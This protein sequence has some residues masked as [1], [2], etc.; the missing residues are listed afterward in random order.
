VTAVAAS[1]QARAV[2]ADGTRNTPS[3]SKVQVA[4]PYFPAEDIADIT[5]A[6]GSILESGMLMQGPPVPA[7]EREFAAS[8]GAA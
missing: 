5:A 8:V 6:V 1:T 7:F 4:K 2:V 3:M